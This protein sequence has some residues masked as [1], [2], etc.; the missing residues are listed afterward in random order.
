PIF[1]G[2]HQGAWSECA[3]CHTD[4]NDRKVFTCLDCHEHRQ[5]EMDAKHAGIQGY[6]YQSSEC[7][8][9]HPDGKKGDFAD[10]DN[11][12][13]PIFSGKHNNKWDNDC[14][15]CHIDSND[16]KVFSCLTCHEHNQTKMDDKHL[17]EVNGYVYESSACYDCHPDGR[18]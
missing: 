8:F 4:V 12:Y 16:R 1:S 18:E 5:S 13:F 14:A 6:S 11:L 7:L 3:I 9:C 15:T 2:A 10:H 17:G